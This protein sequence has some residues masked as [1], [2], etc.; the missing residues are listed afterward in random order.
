MIPDQAQEITD[1]L[2]KALALLQ[3][4]KT[5]LEG[6]QGAEEW[7]RGGART[8]PYLFEGNNTPFLPIDTAG[9]PT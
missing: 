6:G 8:P 9:N 2:E 7:Y 4:V 3:E 1:K 5:L